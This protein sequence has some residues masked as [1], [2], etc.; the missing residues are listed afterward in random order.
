MGKV[1]EN[2]TTEEATKLAKLI[3]I[4][5]IST[6][7]GTWQP[8]RVV[9]NYCLACRISLGQILTSWVVE[10]TTSYAALKD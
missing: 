4:H 6:L 10:T 7:K 9:S 3:G 2:V 8:R 5:M 1:G